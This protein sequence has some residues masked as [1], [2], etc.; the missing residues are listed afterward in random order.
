MFNMPNKSHQTV[1]LLP[2]YL[3]TCRYQIMDNLI[4]LQDTLLQFP[5]T[6]IQLQN[7]QS[8]VSSTFATAKIDKVFYD[9]QSRWRVD[10]RLFTETVSETDPNSVEPTTN[11]L[12]KAPDDEETGTIGR[13]NLCLILKTMLS[14]NS[15]KRCGISICCCE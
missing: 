5:N 12:P 9:R 15:C 3:K 7:L 2:L 14:L 6:F 10:V 1:S 8:P 11:M 4:Q 13:Q